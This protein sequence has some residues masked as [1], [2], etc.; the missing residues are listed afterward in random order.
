MYSVSVPPGG[1]F[2]PKLYLSLNSSSSPAPSPSCSL[3]THA[4]LPRSI[5]VDRFQL[6]L[7]H[8]EHRLGSPSTSS[9][10][11]SETIQFFGDTDLEAPVSR[12][13]P[14][15]LL[16]RLRGAEGDAKGKGKEVEEI[17]LH[18]RYQDPVQDRW[19]GGERKD[20]VDVELEWPSV[21]WACEDGAAS[22]CP[23]STIPELSSSVPPSTSLHF[24]SPSA[25]SLSSSTCPPPRPTTTVQ[26]PTGV[27]SDL[28]YVES[29]NFVA[30]WLGALWVARKAWTRSRGGRDEHK[31]SKSD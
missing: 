15:A 30:V 21:F 14:A 9:A 7:L 17:P 16:L 19:A 20:M 26:I 13:G 27:L 18:V 8:H 1:G 11:T 29:I 31:A 25:A 10:P 23:L 5:I 6:S 24:L 2:H 4:N 28:P 22:G 3:W 12:A